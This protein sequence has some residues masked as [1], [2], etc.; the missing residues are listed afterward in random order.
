MRYL[1]TVGLV[2]ALVSPAYAQKDK[3]TPGEQLIGTVIRATP[4]ATTPVPSTEPL[5][6]RDPREKEPPLAHS[7]KSESAEVK[8]ELKTTLRGRTDTILGEPEFKPKVDQAAP[9]IR[10][11]IDFMLHWGKRRQHPE[12]VS[13]DAK[14]TVDGTSTPLANTSLKLPVSGLKTMRTGGGVSGISIDK[15]TVLVDGKEVT[16][17]WHVAMSPRR[18]GGYFVTGV[19]LEK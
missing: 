17:H 16:G 12:L 15:A 7:A 10:D 9:Q 13:N 4:Q 1:L 3:M 2:M 18:N 11:G 14:V 5:A 6:R 8:D 19:T